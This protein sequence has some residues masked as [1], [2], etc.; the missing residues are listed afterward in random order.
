MWSGVDWNQV[1]GLELDPEVTDWNGLQGLD[2]FVLELNQQNWRQN[3]QII[4]L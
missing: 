1:W 3:L 2:G 4:I